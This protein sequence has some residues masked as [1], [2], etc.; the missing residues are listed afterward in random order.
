MFSNNTTRNYYTPPSPPLASCRKNKHTRG[1]DSSPIL[2]HQVIRRQEE[3]LHVRSGR[4]HRLRQARRRHFVCGGRIHE[5]LK[6]RLRLPR[7]GGAVTTRGAGLGPRVVAPVSEATGAGATEEAAKADRS[8]AAPLTCGRHR[9]ERR[10]SA[11]R[12]DTC[13][14]DLRIGP[15]SVSGCR[16]RE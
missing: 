3:A 14:R 10:C 12:G 13:N 9:A 2:Q 6:S 11:T 8:F 1:V 7:V 5:W 4:R 16:R 15:V